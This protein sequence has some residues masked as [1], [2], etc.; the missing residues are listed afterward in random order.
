MGRIPCAFIIGCI[1]LFMY[2]QWNQYQESFQTHPVKGIF[3]NEAKEV[4]FTVNLEVAR[5][6]QEIQQGLMHRT[7][8]APHT[9]ML[10]LFE[11][12]AP[13]SFWM[14]NTLLPLDMIFVTS[15]GRISN[16]IPSVPPKT[17]EQRLST[18]PV[19]YVVELP[20]GTAAQ[21]GIVAGHQFQWNY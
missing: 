21:Y 5:T 11:E 4:L 15:T 14:Q 1:L 13:R 16:I 17:E 19:Q 7:Y 2:V 12:D 10:F 20:G 6:A 8:L 3:L 18:E 9:G